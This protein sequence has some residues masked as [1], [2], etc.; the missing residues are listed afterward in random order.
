MGLQMRGRFLPDLMAFDN[1]SEETEVMLS[2]ADSSDGSDFPGYSSSTASHSRAQSYSS[3]G[4]PQEFSA[5]GTDTPP[6]EGFEGLETVEGVAHFLQTYC[7]PSSL[8]H[9]QRMIAHFNDAYELGTMSLPDEFRIEAWRGTVKRIARTLGDSLLETNQGLAKLCRVNMERTQQVHLASETWVLA[10]LHDKLVD[11]LAGMVAAREADVKS[12]LAK[13]DKLP[14][15]V[16]GVTEEYEDAVLGDAVLQ[17]QSL[18]LARSPLE[19]ALCLKKTVTCMLEGISR[20]K[21][22]SARDD[23]VPC[24]DDLLSLMLLMLTKAKIPRLLAQAM[25]IEHFLNLH[26]DDGLTGELGY[27]LTNL[28]AACAYLQTDQCKRVSERAAPLTISPG[29]QEPSR[30]EAGWGF[31][32]S[33]MSPDDTPPHPVKARRRLG[34]RR[35]SF[36][37]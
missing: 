5:R 18:P 1:D 14:T 10:H 2:Q 4:G 33:P 12:M 31:N 29:L 6:E 20:T 23:F 16:L 3:G 30:H 8:M 21:R 37:K 28:L 27:H 13:L 35:K 36:A 26:L 34:F 11:G 19:K 9:A 25:Y 24:T 15:S 32:E 7:S 22:A 17:F